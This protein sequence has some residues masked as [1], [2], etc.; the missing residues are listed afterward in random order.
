MWTEFKGTHF[1]QDHYGKQ[2]KEDVCGVL[3]I[4]QGTLYQ[5]K[6]KDFSYFF[7]T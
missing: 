6:S 1:L 7:W 3:L 4:L 2:A 5:E